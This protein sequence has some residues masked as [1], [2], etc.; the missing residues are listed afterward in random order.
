M[1]TWS[2]LLRQ[3]RQPRVAQPAQRAVVV[4]G[5]VLSVGDLTKKVEVAALTFSAEAKRK[6]EEAKGRTLSLQELL[7]ENPEGRKARILG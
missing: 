1:N 6:I 4:P 3:H 5:K 7:H 2:S